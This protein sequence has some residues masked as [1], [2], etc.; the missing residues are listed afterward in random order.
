MGAGNSRETGGKPMMDTLEE[1][2][3]DCLEVNTA[4][5]NTEKL[6]FTN[7]W[8]RFIHLSTYTFLDG[9]SLRPPRYSQAALSFPLNSLDSTL[10][11]LT[12]TNHVVGDAFAEWSS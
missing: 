3:A 5:R 10:V 6:S 4:T 9:D 2:L 1:N 8:V 7:L 12:S 11:T